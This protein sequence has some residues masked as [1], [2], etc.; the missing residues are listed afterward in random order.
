MLTRDFITHGVDE[1]FIPPYV[2]FMFE[3]LC[4]VQESI[5]IVIAIWGLGKHTS[6][7]QDAGLSG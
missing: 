6:S 5:I 7:V 4:S 2:I 3:L 1:R